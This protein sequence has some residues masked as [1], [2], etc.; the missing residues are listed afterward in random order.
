MIASFVE[1]WPPSRRLQQLTCVV[2]PNALARRHHTH[3]NSTGRQRDPSIRHHASPRSGR[4]VDMLQSRRF[5]RRRLLPWSLIGQPSI[6]SVN[7][8]VSEMH[9][10]VDGT[11]TATKGRS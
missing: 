8:T 6:S 1:S 2:A 10:I 4:I 5:V 7:T 11:T 9:A 3:T